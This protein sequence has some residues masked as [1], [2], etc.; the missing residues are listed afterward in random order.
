MKP[1][2]DYARSQNGSVV[3][4]ELPSWYAFFQ[5]YVLVEESVS[6]GL[7][8]MAPSQFSHHAQERFL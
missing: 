5:K 1:V 7:T 4:E 3:I 8:L 2:A 6:Q